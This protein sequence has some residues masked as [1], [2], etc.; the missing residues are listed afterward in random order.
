VGIDVTTSAGVGFVVTDEQILDYAR[1][2]ISEFDE[3][4]AYVD[5][6]AYDVAQLL[7]TPEVRLDDMAFGT[8][9]DDSEDDRA[10]VLKR[11]STSEDARR[12]DG[13]LSLNLSIFAVE[14]REISVLIDA[15][16]A[17]GVVDEGDKDGALIRISFLA[18]LWVS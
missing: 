1:K 15:M 14:D 17:L 2:H 6:Y 5:E 13:G 7:S 4:Y 3:K 10:I 18:G 9:Y 11:R 16:Y 8:M 12:G